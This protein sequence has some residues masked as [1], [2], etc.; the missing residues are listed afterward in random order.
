VAEGGDVQTIVAP[1]PAR[2][3]TLR[4]Y[5][6]K[7][8]SAVQQ[9][10]SACWLHVLVPA[11]GESPY[12]ADALASVL[13]TGAGDLRLTVVDDGTPGDAV[14]AVCRAAGPQVEYVRLPANLGVAGAF[15]ACAERSAGTYTLVMGS[16]DLM[17][18]GYPA[19]LRAL[20]ARFSDP[21]LA[22]TGVTVVDSSGAVVRPLP[23]RVKSLMT[24][25]GGDARLLSG[26]SLVAGLLT[27]NWLY[28][29]ALAWRT[30]VLR[31]H[32]FRPDMETALDLDA[33]LRVLLGGGSLAW[34]PE[35]VFRYRRHGASVSSR[36]AAGGERFAEEQA[37]YR[38]AG[39]QASSL[40]WRRSAFAA[41]LQATSRLHRGMARVARLRER[42]SVVR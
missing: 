35:K 2:R 31:A 29:P 33:E 24:P 39:Q 11:F 40:G 4:N 42:G 27:G 18:P 17:E 13:A 25:R 19:V 9:D 10:E 26:D 21:D 3:C 7:G 15:Q 20:V 1:A 30:D 23:D 12:L 8:F 36:S 34:T 14:A 28:F 6:R 37:L 41:R 22:T 32:G 5:V 16:D 38:W